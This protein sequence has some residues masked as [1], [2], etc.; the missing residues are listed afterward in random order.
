MRG[1]IMKMSAV[2]SVTAAHLVH[3]AGGKTRLAPPDKTMHKS[4]WAT[5]SP[6]PH[7]AAK[8]DVGAVPYAGLRKRLEG[9]NH[10]FAL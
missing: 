7:E 4:I 2:R 10:F 3:R 6:G 5:L 8:G 1:S 9:Q